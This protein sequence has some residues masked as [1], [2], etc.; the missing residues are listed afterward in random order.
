MFILIIL[1]KM[2]SNGLS[3]IKTYLSSTEKIEDKCRYRVKLLSL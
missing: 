2:N 1:D 3:V